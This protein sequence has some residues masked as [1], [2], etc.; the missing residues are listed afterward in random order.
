MRKPSPVCVDI[1]FESIAYK[2]VEFRVADHQV[3]GEISSCVVT[4]GR[5]RVD[6]WRAVPD[7][8]S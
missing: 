3:M 8:D 4:S 6:T 2:D 5:Q 7:K 1:L